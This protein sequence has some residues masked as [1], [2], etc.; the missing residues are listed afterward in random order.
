LVSVIAFVLFYHPTGP[1]RGKLVLDTIP[2]TANV[3]LDGA[4]RGITPLVIED[5]ASGDHQ[6]RIELE[7]YEPEQLI[8]SVKPGDQGSSHVIPLVP[9]KEPS[10]MPPASPSPSGD[11]GIASSPPVAI[12]FHEVSPTPSQ[13]KTATPSESPS[14][15]PSPAPPISQKEIDATREEVTKRI[16][17]LPGITAGE[18]AN[19]IEKMFKARSMERLAVIPFAI[20]QSVLHRAAADELVNTFD[21]PEMRDKL[22]D[23]TIILVV[24][25][26]ADTGGRVDENL[27]ISQ[28]RAENVTKILKQRA[29]LFNA[30]QAVAMGGTE[31][32]DNQR[33]DQNRAVEIWEVVPF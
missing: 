4:S 29:K 28:E 13:E 26:Y 12:P 3:F 23:P 27:R 20:G 6:L 2:G 24:A 9:V 10:R 8:V 31:L 15:G 5:V 33:P 25:G 32:L 21:K 1:K 16:D 18:K 7:G 22:S 11:T 14:V 19:L 17:A 30:I